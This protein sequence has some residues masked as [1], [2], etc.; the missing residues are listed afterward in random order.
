VCEFRIAR[1]KSHYTGTGRLKKT[2]PEMQ[3]YKPDLSKLVRAVEDSLTDAKIWTDDSIEI[4]LMASAEWAARGVE[5]GVR[6]EVW[7]TPGGE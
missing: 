4:G 2:T 3:T 7:T 1:P 5:P 6:V